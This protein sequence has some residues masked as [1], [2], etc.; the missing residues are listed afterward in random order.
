[1]V[2][3]KEEHCVD[4]LGSQFVEMISSKNE[5]SLALLAAWDWKNFSDDFL[6]KLFS[7]FKEKV[8]LLDFWASFQME[9]NSSLYLI[10]FKLVKSYKLSARLFIYESLPFLLAKYFASLTTYESSDEIS[11]VESV[12]MSIYN[13][14]ARDSSGQ[15][16]VDLFTLPEFNRVSVYHNP[17]AGHNVHLTEKALHE[18]DREVTGYP[19]MGDIPEIHSMTPSERFNVMRIALY[20]YHL[21]ISRISFESQSAMISVLTCGLLRGFDVDSKIKASFLKRSMWKESGERDVVLRCELDDMIENIVNSSTT[22]I[23]LDPDFVEL[24]FPIFYFCSASQ[25]SDIS[26]RVAYAINAAHNRAQHELWSDTLMLT[27]IQRATCLQRQPKDE[28]SP[29]SDGLLSFPN[30]NDNLN[31]P[32]CNG[33]L[34]NISLN[35]ERYFRVFASPLEVEDFFEDESSPEP[36][37]SSPILSPI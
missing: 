26:S 37:I 13:T 11:S 9:N 4:S 32:G 31:I 24:M 35:P 8:S 6:E 7:F 34:P 5:Q 36:S 21:H 20:G 10:L 15:P 18:H 22:R 19:Y 28:E 12:L 23:P 33:K 3:A 27:N 29:I 2:N 25:F 14:E 30:E 1:M 17:H 16:I